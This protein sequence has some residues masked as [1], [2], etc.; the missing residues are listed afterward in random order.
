ML[1]KHQPRK[2]FGQN[3]L[4]DE[5][6][7]EHIVESIAP[8]KEDQLVEIGPGLG[9]LTTKFLPRVNHLDVIELDRDLIP[10]LENK[11]QQL[12]DLTIYN[13]DVLKFDFK[14]LIKTGSLLRV[15]GNLPYNISTPLL[16]HLLDQITLIKDM[17]F[18][19]QKELVDRLTAKPGNKDYGRLSVMVQY[20]CDVE[21]LFDVPS[22]AFTPKPK[23]E[24]AIVRL[25]PYKQIPY[26]AN[27]KAIFDDVVRRAFMH[28]RKTLHNNIKDLLN[29][30]GLIQLAIDPKIRPEQ[31]TV[32]QYVQIAN[33]I[34]KEK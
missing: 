21:L 27:N 14:K 29:D 20:Y 22:T 9:A 31:L 4:K 13:E 26:P 32:A 15:I 33:A 12:G 11:C 8:E 3:F 24:S 6:I 28:R 34:D 25:I 18:M 16:F 17:V 2:R 1:E 30:N 7:I 19:F 10:I 5:M 23:V